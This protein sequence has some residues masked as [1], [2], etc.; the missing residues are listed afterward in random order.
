MIILPNVSKLSTKIYTIM[1]NNN[2]FSK[3]G[4]NFIMIVIKL[5]LQDYKASNGMINF[6]YSYI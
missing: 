3:H 5:P 6:K 4:H 1:L 2:T